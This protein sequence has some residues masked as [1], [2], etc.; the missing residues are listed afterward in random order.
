[1]PDK[2]LYNEKNNKRKFFY[3]FLFSC[4]FFSIVHILMSDF[5]TRDIMD[6]VLLIIWFIFLIKWA[7]F[8]VD[9]GSS[10]AKNLGISWLVIWLV[11]VGFGT[12]A[13]EFVVS[14]LSASDGKTDLSISN[15]L[16]SNI[17]NIFLILWVTSIVYPVIMPD[18]TVKK[19]I[20]F[21][22]WI[23]I[24]LFVF[25]SD[26]VLSRMDG[27]ICLILFCGFMYYSYTISG[28]QTSTQESESEVYTKL[29][30][31]IYIFAWLVWLI[32]G[33]KLIVDS[34]V[35]IALQFW[36]S[37]AFV[38]VTIVAIGTSLPELAASVI[39]AFKKKTDMAIGGVVGSNLFNVLW[40]WWATSLFFPIQ[41]YEWINA[42][43]LVNALATLLL[44]VTAYILTLKKIT[45]IE[46]VF[47]V[48]LY[49]S[50]LGFLVSQL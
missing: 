28:Q 40:I 32:V 42:D 12:S 1:M 45:K 30:S 2:T 37:E 49:L 4:C 5:L 34:A 46:W 10:L 19:E 14:M 41:A 43:L 22:T 35:S 7:D 9:G 6:L 18:S 47:F 15:I 11:I 23:A 33:G 16:W 20:P 36:L 21:L 25:L 44:L 50:Y 48:I 38:W 31:S 27:V 29:K 26:G 39:A 13:P 24:L 3:I 8:L 17:S